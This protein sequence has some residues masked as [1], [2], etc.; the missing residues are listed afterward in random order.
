MNRLTGYSRLIGLASVMMLSN[1]AYAECS[2]DQ[3][4]PSGYSVPD[5]VSFLAGQGNFYCD[6]IKG[7]NGQPMTSVAGVILQVNGDWELPASAQVTD[8]NGL[9]TNT[10]DYIVLLPKGKGTRCSFPYLRENAVK[11]TGLHSEGIVDTDN[12]LACT[13]GL[14]NNAE[15]PLPAPDLVTTTGDD[16]DITLSATTPNGTVTESDFDFFTGSSL[17]GSIQAICNAGGV[18][19]NECVRSCPEFLNIEERQNLG[20]CQSDT[21]GWIPLTDPSIP[22]SYSTDKRCTPCLTAAEAEATIPGFDSEGQKLCWEYTNSVNQVPGKYRAH[23]SIRSQTTQTDLYN[24]CYTTT[25]TVNFFGR[26]LT[27]TITTCK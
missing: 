25:T 18:I 20:Y 10:P 19:Q 6:D 11:G 7:S 12:S 27:K 4:V 16:C 1:A 17:D 13:D 21:G 22:D 2:F 9:V 5:G 26:E 14:V 3:N 8:S 24:E 23:K 15:V